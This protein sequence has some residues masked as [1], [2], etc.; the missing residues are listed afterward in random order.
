FFYFR[1]F[2]DEPDGFIIV[3]LDISFFINRFLYD[4]FYVVAMNCR[5]PLII[6]EIPRLF[7]TIFV[8]SYTVFK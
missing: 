2:V 5:K 3:F 6:L 8:I 1:S 4:Y 7:P